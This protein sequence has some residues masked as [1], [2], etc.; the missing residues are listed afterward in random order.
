MLEVSQSQA[1]HLV[2]DVQGLRSRRPC[3]SVLDVVRR[4]HNVQIDT[5][6]VVSRSHDLTVFNRFP[7]YSEGEVWREER[8][9]RL[10]EYWSHA[11][12]LL[13]VQSFPFYAW[14]M[15]RMSEAKKGWQVE[16]GVKN[17]ETIES[18]LEHVKA[19]GPTASSDIGTREQ[20]SDGWWD[21]KKEKLALEY[22][23]VTGRL[24]VAYREGFQK[25]YDLTERVL[26]PAIPSEPMAIDEIPEY[27]VDTVFRSIGLGD[28]RDLKTYM[29]GLP[30]RET[31]GGRQLVEST[32]KEHIGSTVE[33][34]TVEGH[35]DPLYVHKAYTDALTGSGPDTS[36]EHVM[37]LSP[38]DNIVRERHY[39]RWL[40]TFDYKIEC[41]T[42]VNQRKYG[43][44]ALP[45][46]DGSAL[47]GRVDAKVHR[48]KGLLELK[49]LY[50]EFDSL[51]DDDGAARFAG[52]LERFAKFHG[53]SEIEL[54]S[55]M[56][57]GLRK[58][59]CEV[60][61]SLM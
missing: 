9:G 8:A 53:C 7:K 11:M 25:Y 39:P 4:V 14:I 60:I 15:E 46:L 55:V 10:F 51:K 24:L 20:K 36:S 40:W 1:Q 16:W 44:Y 42:P 3:R 27:V 38:F 49:S 48:D 19:K 21:W 47:A 41:Y 31:W 58:R 5:I 34:V 32:L 57:R 12:C 26:P 52:G 13:P 29:G 43:Y 23:L 17:K 56:P 50:I 35:K 33:Q 28:Y 18:V 59:Y 2:L 6:S 45:I 54:H 30:F 22:L 61:S 37:L